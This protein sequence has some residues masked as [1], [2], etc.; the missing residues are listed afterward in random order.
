MNFAAKAPLEPGKRLGKQNGR[1]FGVRGSTYAVGDGIRR[2]TIERSSRPVAWPEGR[3][4][5]ALSMPRAARRPL[6]FAFCCFPPASPTS[7]DGAGKQKTVPKD[8]S[9]P[10]ISLRKV[11]AG[12]GIR[13]LDPNLGNVLKQ[14]TP[15]HLFLSRRPLSYHP[16]G[17]LIALDRPCRILH[18]PG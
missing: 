3:E 13:T 8:R 14:F 5:R 16:V 12:E 15:Q 4:S 1:R 7:V 11:G 10:L 17:V 6:C 9:K 2:C 18:I